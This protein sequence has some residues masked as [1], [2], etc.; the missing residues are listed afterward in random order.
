MAENRPPQRKQRLRRVAQALAVALSS[1]LA[2]PSY[3]D[4]RPRARPR[5][6]PPMRFVRVTSAEPACKPNCPEWLSAEG[7]IE[8]GS[9]KAFADAIAD[10]QGRRLAG[11]LPSPRGPAA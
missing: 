8:P 2:L 11:L 9:A 3:A 10:L 1:L 6:T 7:R 5:I 4:L